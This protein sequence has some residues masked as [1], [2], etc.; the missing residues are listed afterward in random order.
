MNAHARFT[1]M[2]DG[3]EED[4]AIIAADFNAYARQLPSRLLAHLK[5]LEG[6]FGGFPVDRLTHSLQTA[7]R[8]F[9]DGR[10]EEYVVC[11]LLHDIGD[12]LGSYNHPD[13]A[14]A[15]LKPFVSAENLWMVE[16]HGIFQGYYFFHHL[17]MDRHLREQFKD[18]PQFQATAEFCAKY[19]AAAF[20]PA[21]DTLPLSFFEPMMERLFAQPKNSIYKAAMQEHSPA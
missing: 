21:Y 18:H 11:A 3:T 6:D 7:T 15:I 4:W 10:D 17:G 1:H 20:D 5:L 2:K 8:A 13:I 14:A 19:D 9:R 16:K 12:T